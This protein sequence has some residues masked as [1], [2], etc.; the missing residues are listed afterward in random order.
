M[1]AL[2]N[3]ARLSRHEKIF[4]QAVV[5]AAQSKRDAEHLALATCGAACW[6]AGV[7]PGS[8]VSL[9]SALSELSPTR[10]NVVCGE[11]TQ[12]AQDASSN[13]NAAHH[14]AFALL[15]GIV[16]SRVIE[17]ARP[18]VAAEAAD[19]RDRALA[20]AENLTSTAL[21]LIGPEAEGETAAAPVWAFAPLLAE[22]QL[23]LEAG[24]HP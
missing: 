10:W 22:R 16:D 13:G 18:S 7:A 23:E 5:S 6:L 24:T 3:R 19:F 12:A 21:S 15:A 4:K 14:L 17:I 11:L 20:F 8:T 2:G 9:R 1:Y